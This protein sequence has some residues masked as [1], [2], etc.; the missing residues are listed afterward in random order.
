MKFIRFVWLIF[1]EE[2]LPCETLQKIDEGTLQKTAKNPYRRL[3]IWL[4]FR[5]LQ[6]YSFQTWHGRRISETLLSSTSLNYFDLQSWS[7][8][9]ERWKLVHPFSLKYLC[10][11]SWNVVCSHNLFCWS[12]CEIYFAQLP[13]KGEKPTNVISFKLRIMLDVTE[14]FVV[15][16]TDRLAR[17]ESCG[18]AKTV[19]LCCH[20][21]V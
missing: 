4:T 18:E 2:T 14:L 11:F 15:W 10:W 20:I 21:V 6:N 19:Q 12:P 1:K 8:M 13:F 5:Y 17:S 16:M 3:K 9:Y 7:Q